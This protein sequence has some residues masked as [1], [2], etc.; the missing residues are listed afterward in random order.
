MHQLNF[1]TDQDSLNFRILSYAFNGT[2][3]QKFDF[4]IVRALS[5]TYILIV[6]IIIIIAVLIMHFAMPQCVYKLHQL[7]KLYIT[8]YR[9]YKKR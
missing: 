8:L 6:I 9:V 7:R 5:S 3:S 4:C 1:R 2:S